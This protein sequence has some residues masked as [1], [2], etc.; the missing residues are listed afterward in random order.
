LW[1]RNDDDDD[2]I[3]ALTRVPHLFR[4]SVLYTTTTEEL[5]LLCRRLDDWIHKP[6][7]QK[8]TFGDND[9]ADGWMDE[10][11]QSSKQEN[12]DLGT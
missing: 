6:G 1:H 5:D 3:S 12:Y 2:D 11:C 8:L 4:A 10:E 7:E 9:G